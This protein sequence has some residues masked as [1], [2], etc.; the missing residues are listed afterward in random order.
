MPEI[1]EAIIALAAVVLVINACTAVW[2]QPILSKN[3]IKET[4]KALFA[5]LSLLS[6]TLIISGSVIGGTPIGDMSALLTGLGLFLFWWHIIRPAKEIVLAGIVTN[7]PALIITT[8][9]VSGDM[10][11]AGEVAVM[12]LIT[13]LFMS[14]I[15]VGLY[16]WKTK[17]NQ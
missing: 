17:T 1:I 15:A 9:I 13:L 5:E 14:A 10:L 16:A 8:I 11:R 6:L 2:L 3:S 12:S 4:W 7:L